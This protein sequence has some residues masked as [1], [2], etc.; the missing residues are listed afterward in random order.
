VLRRR[1]L[2]VVAVCAVL[3]SGTVVPAVPAAAATT[4]RAATTTG[5]PVR[6]RV[7]PSTRYA[8]LGWVRHG[9]PVRV[10][11]KRR[12]QMIDGRFGRSSTWLKIRRGSY[13]PRTYVRV[14]PRAVRRLPECR[15]SR[16]DDYFLRGTTRRVDPFLFYA[17]YCTS[18]A[19]WRVNQ[20][21]TPFTNGYRGVRWGNAEHWDNA[22]RAVGVRVSRRPRRGDVAQWNPWRSGARAAGHVAFVRKVHRDGTITVEEYNWERPLRFGR[23]RI[24]ARSV[25]NFIRF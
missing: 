4:G 11:C 22:A 1:V 3:V 21:G 16:G 9:R 13:L 17:R 25:S 8:E 20:H 5:S 7:G 12:G 18:F 14:R 15:V 10:V 24:P 19:A 6:V 23:R 2:P